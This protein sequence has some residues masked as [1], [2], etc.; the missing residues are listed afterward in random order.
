VALSAF[1]AAAGLAGFILFDGPLS[2][3]LAV[4]AGLSATIELILLVSLP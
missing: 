4:L 1:I 2:W 3:V